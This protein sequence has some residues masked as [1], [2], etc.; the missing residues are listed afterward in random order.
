[1]DDTRLATEHSPPSDV[2]QHCVTHTLHALYERS[3]RSK[4]GICEEKNHNM[5][6][7]LGFLFHTWGVWSFVVVDNRLVQRPHYN[8]GKICN[9]LPMKACSG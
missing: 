1:M 5:F 2:L 3:W 4:R 7:S 8:A 9:V 6:A